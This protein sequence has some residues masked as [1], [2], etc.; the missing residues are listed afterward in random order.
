MIKV[1]IADDQ[2]LI[3]ESL[4]IVLGANPD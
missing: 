4:G 1:L 3:R 2:E